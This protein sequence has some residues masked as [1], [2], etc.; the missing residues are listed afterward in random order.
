MSQEGARSV[1]LPVFGRRRAWPSERVLIRAVARGEQDA[2]HELFDRFWPQAHHAA[3]LIL[4]DAHH[5]TCAS[6]INPRA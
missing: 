2:V 6:S 1:S 5:G 4:R 3:W